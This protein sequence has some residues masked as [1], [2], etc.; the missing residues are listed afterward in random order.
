MDTELIHL[1]ETVGQLLK[2]NFLTIAIAESCT[3]GGICQLL[4]EIS[5]SS[6]WFECGFIC[7]SNHSKS[8]ML[9]VKAETLENFGAVSK[10]TAIEMAHGA[11]KNSGADYTISVTG[12]AGPEGGSLEKPVGTVFIA[13]QNK[14]THRCYQMYFDGTRHEIRQQTIRFALTALQEFISNS[15][16]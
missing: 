8:K 14:T 6:S 11:L 9:G 15:A 12:I 10:E 13:L 16:I 7:Y 2:K 4:T 1:A 3:G 5:G